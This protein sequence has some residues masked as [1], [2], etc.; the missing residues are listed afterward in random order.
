M[1]FSIVGRCDREGL[2]GVAVA[3]KFLAVGAVVPV[4]RAE[5]GAVATQAYANPAYG[6]Q[7]MTLLET[8]VP[9]VDAVA[10]VAAADRMRTHRQV[11]VVTPD[12][13]GASFTGDECPDWAGGRT[14]PGVAVQGNIL[15][16]PQVVDDMIDR[17]ERDEALPLAN[18]LLAALR[19]GD[20]AGGD[21]RG[22]Q[23]AALY[24]VGTGRG[25]LG[26]SDVA[27]DL[28]VD[29]HADPVGELSRLLRLHDLYFGSPVVAE[30]L[31]LVGELADEVRD[32]LARLGYRGTDEPLDVTMMDW[33]GVANLE[34]RM[35]PGRIDPIVLGQLRI[36][37]DRL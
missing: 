37:V 1:T 27:V 11:G 33:A 3:S 2:L 8:G 13:D 31:P 26:G 17:W 22:R 6:P 18:R 28:R 4:A 24:V 25:Y 5:V 7:L 10:G 12:G 14:G 29:D 9:A 36:D 20:D 35:L 15:S 34:M 23:S 19:A 30:A 16:G 32:L 21:R